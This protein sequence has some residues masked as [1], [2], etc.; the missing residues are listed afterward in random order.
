MLFIALVVIPV[1]TWLVY[2]YCEIKRIQQKTHNIP[3][4][5]T[6]WI[7]GNAMEFITADSSGK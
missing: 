7:F 5:P 2:Q 4:P 3:G 6:K 1:L